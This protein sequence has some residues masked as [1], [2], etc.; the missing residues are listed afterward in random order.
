MSARDAIV[1]LRRFGLGPRPGEAHAISRDPRG[2][3]LASLDKPETLQISAPLESTEVLTRKIGDQQAMI[4]NAR[5]AP[6]DMQ[7][8][9]DETGKGPMSGEKMGP[10]GR[11]VGGIFQAEVRARIAHAVRTDTGFLERLALFWANHFCVSSRK[12]PIL[13]VTAGSYEREAIRPNVL[14]RFVNMVKATATH[15]AMLHYLDNA[16]SVG[17]NSRAGLRRAAGLNE[18]YARELLE[19][20][21]VGVNA[22]YTQ[23]DVTSLARVMTGWTV[24]GRDRPD[25]GKFLFAPHVHEPGAQT[26]L[27]RRYAEGGVEQGMAVIADLARHPAT[28]TYVATRLA[29][30]FVSENPPPRLVEQLALTFRE[31]EGDLKALARAL[32]MA[33]EA[34]TAP[35]RKILPPFDLL[36]ATYRGL[37]LFPPDGFANSTLNVF[38]QPMWAVPS[39]KGWPDEDEHWAAPKAL[40][41]RIDWAETLVKRFA[42]ARQVSYLAD[43]LYAGTLSTQTREAIARAPNIADSLVLFLMSTEVQRR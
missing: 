6:K 26:V 24:A 20:H 30:H 23:A 33:D 13:R 43:D 25:Y 3:L 14:G 4:R 31:T 41:E 37:V 35:P 29:R 10:V 39:P 27:G 1:A 2:Y 11:V 42:G 36:I 18:N 16:R 38:G 34:W 8:S 15:P 9:G 28:A 40:M 19:L 7:G 12:S 5:A 21:T 17:P 22:R 32:V